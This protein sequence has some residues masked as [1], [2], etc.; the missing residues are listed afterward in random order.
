[1]KTPTHYFNSEE[2]AKILGVNVSTIKR[3][4]D[5]GELKCIK[6]KGGHRKFF[7]EHLAE[8]LK[9]NKRQTSRVNLF[10]VENERDLEISYQILKADFD[11]LIEFVLQE[12]IACYRDRVLQVLNGLYL[13]D[14]ALDVIY[15]KLLTPVFHKIGDLWEQQQ[16]T[17]IEEHLASQTIRDCIIRLQGII[18]LPTEKVGTVLCLNPATELHDSALKMV[19]HLLEL[20][21]FHVLYSGQITPVLRVEKLFERVKPARVYISSTYVTDVKAAQEEFDRL[22]E[23]C[24]LHHT[25]LFIGGGG[26]DLLK[27]NYPQIVMRLYN[28]K[29]VFAV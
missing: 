24:T 13:G 17:I 29:D 5:L 10:P 7:I 18:R 14:H 16:L 3:W 11:Y 15:D 25:K 8:F 27:V 2:A 23:L 20:R 21:G 9:E 28:F 6:T 22:C 1:M 26:F 19:D 12:A 4:T